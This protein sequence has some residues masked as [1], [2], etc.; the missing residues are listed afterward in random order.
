MRV[1]V[2]VSC[3]RVEFKSRNGM[4]I[5]CAN[6]QL[7]YE[8]LSFSKSLGYDTVFDGELLV[9]S[10]TKE[11][12]PRKIGNGICNKA[13]KGTI[14]DVERNLFSICIWDAIPYENFLTGSCKTPYKDRLAAY[15]AAYSPNFTKISLVPS[16][17]VLSWN[18][19]ELIY[20]RV[21][22]QGK[23]GLVIKNQSG[24]WADKRSGDLVKMKESHVCELL[25]TKWVEGTG[26]FEGLMGALE[27]ESSGKNPI[28]VSVGTGFSDEERRNITPKNIVGKI[29]SVIYNEVITSE[30]G[31]RSLFLPRF[32][33]IRED[34]TEAD[35][36][37]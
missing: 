37:A 7:I 22:S 25:V 13:I 31:T 14:S 5:D 21:V 4:L 6:P 24:I 34:K 16:W 33:E 19:A 36:I 18:Q 32:D 23:E 11:P 28:R 27:C 30:D 9:M 26:K 29:I 2:I 12:L 3:G 17:E 35:E 15:K 10:T 20:C 8:F 1:N